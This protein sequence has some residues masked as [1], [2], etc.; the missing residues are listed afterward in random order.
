MQIPWSESRR[1]TLDTRRCTPRTTTRERNCRRH[2]GGRG[3]TFRFRRFAHTRAYH[4]STP[5][6]VH[7]DLPRITTLPHEFSPNDNATIFTTN[8]SRQLGFDT[9]SELEEKNFGE[10]LWSVG[11]GGLRLIVTRG[12]LTFWGTCWGISVGCRIAFHRIFLE[13]ILRVNTVDFGFPG[14][15]C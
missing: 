2:G 15:L 3:A 12:V 9:S 8:R 11:Y 1:S 4:I 5:A 10:V 7:A 14:F 13:V 6:F